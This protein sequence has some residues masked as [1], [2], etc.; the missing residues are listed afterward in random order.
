MKKLLALVAISTVVWIAH[1]FSLS[2]QQKTDDVAASI[3]RLENEWADAQKAG[4]AAVVAP[5]LADTFINTDVDGK[6]SG[7]TEL[8]S[9]LKGGKW[10]QN[11]ISDVKA[12]VY[13]NTAIATGAWVGKGVDGDGTKVDRHERWTDAWVKMP[14]GKWQCVASQQSEVKK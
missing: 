9:S 7:K 5:M 14:N 10:E 1:P 2:A 12:A 6:V 8:L 11:G 4:N 13:G 3:V